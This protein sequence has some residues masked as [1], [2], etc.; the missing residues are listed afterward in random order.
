MNLISLLSQILGDF[1][2]F[3]NGEHY[4]NCPFCHNYNKHFAVN[5]VKR[6]WQC[7]VC[8][9]KGRSIITLFKKLDVS[10]EQLQEL[11]E[12]LPEEELRTYT[13]PTDTVSTLHLP[14]GYK[15]LWIPT[16]NIQY[17]HA[18]SYLKA[19]GI[20]GHDI[21]RYQMGY[22]IEQPYANRIIIPSFDKDN[23]LNYFIARSFYDDGL[24][25]KNPPVSKNVIMFENQ[26]NWKLPIILCE[27]VFDA[28][29]IR[30]NAIPLLGKFIPRKLLQAILKNKVKDVSIV[31]DVDAHV[32]AQE[33]EHNLSMYDIK[34]K[35]VKLEGKDPSDLGF[36]KTWDCINEGQSSTFKDYINGR[37]QN[38]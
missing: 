11:R 27:G 12:L 4:F 14:P 18:I 31:L 1:D 9:A 38:I 32:Q 24:R 15:P 25:Y 2:Q 35:L 3:S 34:V 28:I 33:L 37:L 23:K 6:K 16:N 17:R 7:W 26:I 5:V 36:C 22:T 29:A 8:G 13:E 10:K 19:R 20:T 21:I 30:R